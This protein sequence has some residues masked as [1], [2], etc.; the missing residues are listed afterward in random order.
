MTDSIIG[1]LDPHRHIEAVD[2]AA[3][4]L[5]FL[6]A[7]LVPTITHHDEAVP[8]DETTWRFSTGYPWQYAK[9]ADPET[10]IRNAM[11]EAR[12]GR[13]EL[14]RM[15]TAIQQEAKRERIPGLSAVLRKME[16]QQR[17][18]ATGPGNSSVTNQ[19]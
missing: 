10:A 3:E 8:E 2:D 12:T 18:G 19:I 5:R 6:L 14:R 11:K 1:R 9:G 7:R 16:Q 13:R 4:L 15:R 17:D